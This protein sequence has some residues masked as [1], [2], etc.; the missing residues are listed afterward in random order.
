[1][2]FLKKWI[3]EMEV[4][5]M[6]T[7]LWDAVDGYKTYILAA[8]G[9]VVAVAGHFFG[10]FALGSLQVPQFSWGEVWNI[11]WNGGLFSF[12]HAKKP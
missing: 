5:R 10:P 11:V 8:L 3:I 1:M 9:I 2:N 12:L 6:L 7:K 4:Q